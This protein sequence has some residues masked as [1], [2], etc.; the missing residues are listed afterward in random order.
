MKAQT[1]STRRATDLKT[2]APAKQMPMIHPHAAG[3]DVGATK[4]FVCVPEDAVPAGERPVRE[5]SAFTA[6]LDRLVEWLRVCG[7]TTVAMESTGVYWI[8]LYQKIEAAGLEAVLVNARH[9]K[10]VPGRKSDVLDCQ[11]LQRLQSY[12]LLQ[13]SFRPSDDICALRTYM[14]HRANLVADCGRQ[15]QHMQKALDQM[16]IHLH[17]VVSDLDGDTGLRIIEAI[18]SGERDP[19]ELVKL[20]D[21]R[22]RKSTVAEMEA[23]LKGDWRE[24]HLLVLAQALQMYR[25][26]EAQRAQCD[27]RI[28]KA[29]AAITANPVEELEQRPANPMAAPDSK[30]NGSENSARATLPSR[31]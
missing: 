7:V 24:E 6:D 17:H 18:L 31:I 8:P 21:P 30:K 29:L 25:F 10:H 28:E 22:V 1:A 11:W 4:H 12:G 9:L 5:F 26:L 19:K 16:N 15:V 20:R 3:I 13:A 23:A 2:I 14:R 27:N